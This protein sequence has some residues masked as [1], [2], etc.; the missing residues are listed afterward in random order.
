VAVN[1]KLLEFMINLS[2]VNNPEPQGGNPV[3]EASSQLGEE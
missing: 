1:R 2:E 3:F